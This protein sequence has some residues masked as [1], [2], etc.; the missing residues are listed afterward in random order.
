MGIS[1]LLYPLVD[2]IL[3]LLFLRIDKMLRGMRDLWLVWASAGIARL[4]C[5]AW[6]LA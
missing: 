6:T 1:P 4:V 3:V 2:I 5:V